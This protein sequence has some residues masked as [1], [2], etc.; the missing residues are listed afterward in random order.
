MVS[1]KSAPIADGI[2]NVDGV[3]TDRSG[4]TSEQ[5]NRAHS[6]LRSVGAIHEGVRD[7]H[8]Q[9]ALHAGSHDDCEVIVD[10]NENRRHRE[11]LATA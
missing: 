10:S 11:V 8:G 9:V 2:L 3:V 6:G 7:G 1:P 5:S 4:V